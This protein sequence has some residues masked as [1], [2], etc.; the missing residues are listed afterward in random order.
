MHPDQ[1]AVLRR[2]REHLHSFGVANDAQDHGSIGE[3]ERI[4]KQ[5]YAGIA[6]LLA[7]HSFLAELL[8]TLRWEVDSGNVAGGGWSKLEDAADAWLDVTGAR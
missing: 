8:P 7:E 4:R 3:A 1:R 2:L 6:E 5:S